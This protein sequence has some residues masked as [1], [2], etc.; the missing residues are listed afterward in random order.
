MPS[1]RPLTGTDFERVLAINAANVPAVGPID[2]EQLAFLVGESCVALVVEVGA[3]ANAVVAGFCLVLPPGSSYGSVNYRWFMDRCDTAWYLDRVAFDAD[4]QG[5]GLGAALYAA[6]DR[7]IAAC[8]EAGDAVDRLT[9]EVN[10]DPPNPA[11]LAFHDRLGFVEVGRQ[12]TPY[13]TEVSLMQK[14]Y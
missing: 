3:D 4:Y 13:G 8:R 2:R 11:S 1:I 14:T 12:R 6:V 5:R 10:V 7:D 9:L